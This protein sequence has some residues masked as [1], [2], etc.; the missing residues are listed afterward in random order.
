VG[1]RVTN[2]QRPD[3]AARDDLLSQRERFHTE[4]AQ[5]RADWSRLNGLLNDYADEHD[6]CE[7]YDDT[8]ED[9]NSGFRELKLVGGEHDYDVS[10][11]V[12]VTY[13]L[14]LPV[15]ATSGSRA[16]WLGR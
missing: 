3:S 13:D 2:E 4:T 16:S 14:T 9:W 7:Q 5:M 6:M 10:V 12:T 15:T 1:N 11:K 8:L